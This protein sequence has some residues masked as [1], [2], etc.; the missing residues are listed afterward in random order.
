MPISKPNAKTNWTVGNPNFNTVTIEPNNSK[1]Q[2]GWQSAEKP[3]FQYMNWIH[4]I[5]NEW[6]KY[7]EDPLGQITIIN[8]TNSPYNATSLNRWIGCNTTGGNITI[9]LPP[10]ASN[11]GVE[12][13]I[14]KI[15][16]DTNTVTLDGNG[17]ETINNQI[18]YVIK[19]QFETVRLKEING[20][21][22]LTSSAEKLSVSPIR[23]TTYAINL[24]DIGTVIHI[25]STNGSFNLN[26]PTP[27]E[28]FYFTVKDVGGSLSTNPVTLNRAGSEK[29]EM[30]T[31]NYLLQ[32]D[33]GAWNIY[34][35]GTDWFLR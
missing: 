20:Q 27:S 23:T 34:S 16:S 24:L 35:D 29:I 26:L 3:A 12:F 14:A 9:N 6:I 22:V 5:T 19:H 25:N 7:F 32:A 28:G 15:S 2:T 11:T 31:A 13:L 10:V 21:W 30:L 1:K 18:T 4:Y 33:Y 8:N 17:S